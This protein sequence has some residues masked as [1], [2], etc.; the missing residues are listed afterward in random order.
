M[1]WEGDGALYH[2]PQNL[3]NEI[4]T[5]HQT[6]SIM[7]TR[8]TH[9]RFRHVKYLANKLY[10]TL[11]LPLPTLSPWSAS[12]GVCLPASHR[13]SEPGRGGAEPPASRPYGPAATV[14]TGCIFALSCSLMDGLSRPGL[15]QNSAQ[16]EHWRRHRC[17]G[18]EVAT[19]C[20][21]V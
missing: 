4:L 21:G 11:P 13:R 2:G 3:S 5:Y 9:N 18:S 12:R 8:P 16:I 20:V 7:K 17:S 15:G 6:L 1:F 14:Y 10:Q 19:S